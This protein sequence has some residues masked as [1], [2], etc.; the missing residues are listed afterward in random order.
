MEDLE[1]VSRDKTTEHAEILDI[2]MPV[3]SVGQCGHVHIAKSEFG[4]ANLE[5][6]PKLWFW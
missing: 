6:S 2:Q 1:T 3:D 5:I 4:P